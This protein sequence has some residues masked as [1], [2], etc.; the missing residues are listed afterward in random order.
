MPFLVF[1]VPIVGSALHGA[2]ATGY[3]RAGHVCPKLT[4]KQN[5]EYVR[6]LCSLYVFKYGYATCVLVP[7]LLLVAALLLLFRLVML[8]MG[9][10]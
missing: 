2:R 3:D 6:Q 1:A 5:V 10:A 9:T 4:M 8:V 7:L